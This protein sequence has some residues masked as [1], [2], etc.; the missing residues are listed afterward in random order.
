MSIRIINL[1][2]ITKTKDIIE[3]IEGFRMKLNINDYDSQKK[4][5]DRC[6]EIMSEDEDKAIQFIKDNYNSEYKG[7]IIEIMVSYLEETNSKKFTMEMLDFFKDIDDSYCKMSIR[8][9]V[10]KNDWDEEDWF[11]IP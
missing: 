3:I 9:C 8:E 2:D 6:I 5:W 4:F 1:I 7:Y 11:D 10:Y